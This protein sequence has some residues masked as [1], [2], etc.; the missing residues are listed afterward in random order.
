MALLLCRF[1]AYHSNDFE[2]NK[3]SKSIEEISSKTED[4]NEKSNGTPTSGIVDDDDDD[5]EDSFCDA[6]DLNICDKENFKN[7]I[8]L[9]LDEIIFNNKENSSNIQELSIDQINNSVTNDISLDITVDS[10]K[11][12]F[13]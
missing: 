4:T 1:E 6:H 13:K 9:S 3:E 8:V 10:V 2:F 7:K 11:E 12:H 5:D